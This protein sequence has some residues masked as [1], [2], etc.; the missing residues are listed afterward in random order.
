MRTFIA[1]DIPLSE[2]ALQL[3]NRL[4]SS[5]EHENIRWVNFRS[6]HLTLFFL[7][8]TTVAQVNEIKNA[9][10]SGL[11][12]LA[13]FELRLNSAGTF[14]PPRNPTVLWVGIENSERL[15]SL[16]SMV[17]NAVVPLGFTADSRPFKPH[18]TLGR[19][20]GISNI[21]LLKQYIHELDSSINEQVLV[22]RVVFYQS[23]L[24]PNG[25]IY[26]P[27]YNHLL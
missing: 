9:L 3:L 15:K 10:Q 24:T 6:L 2:S 1:I 26:K 23:T 11:N 14:G 19:I 8:D 4:Q 7:G 27:L 16:H 13:P 5:L 18:V 20:K 25:P 22:D 12:S 21:Q 17:T